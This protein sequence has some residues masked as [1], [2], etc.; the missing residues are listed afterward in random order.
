MTDHDLT[1]TLTAVR[2]AVPVPPIDELAFRA[3]VRE[4]RRR[5]TAV[6]AVTAAAAVAAVGAGL[7]L[8]APW[9]GTGPSTDPAGPAGVDRSADPAAVE[10]GGP[11][12]FLQAGTVM[13][14]GPSGRPVDT[15][16]EAEEVLGV[17]ADRIV[18]VGDESRVLVFAV[19]A[20]GELGPGRA[21]VDEPVQRAVLSKDHR[22]IA[23]IDL[24]DTLHVADL[25]SP[26]ADVSVPLLAA[27]TR[28]VAVDGDHWVED[29]GDRLS[30]RYPEQSFEVVPVSD[31]D[32][33]ELAG[34][35]LA[36][37]GAEGVE[38]F[39]ATDGSPRVTGGT[40]GAVGAL[41]PDGS[42][43]VTGTTDADVDRGTPPGLELLDAEDGSVRTVGGPGLDAGLD[44]VLDLSWTGPTFWALVT[45]DG[46]E[47]L[48]E[49]SAETATCE[50]RVAS[51]G[52]L[53][54]PTS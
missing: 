9:S 4:A 6:R 19:G 30:L 13:T 39:D 37:Q 10:P 14:L 15:G 31:P 27:Q 20:D 16:I 47:A 2:D 32:F 51:E 29:E 50:E 1:S 26:R 53:A 54:L 23:W 42:A 35:V 12:A 18:V 52:G 34:P 8:L 38:V 45:R 28:L 41:A 33:A 24:D 48:L 44:W 25:D 22:R 43:Y 21:V 40:G 7:G 11:F 49:C 17:D 36:V 5:R 46:G 3:R